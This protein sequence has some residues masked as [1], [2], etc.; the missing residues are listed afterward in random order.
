[1]GEALQ[2]IMP[3]LTGLGVVVALMLNLMNIRQKGRESNP[4]T[5]E[6]RHDIKHIR[7]RVDE[8]KVAMEKQ[9]EKMDRM[10][11]Q[12]VLNEASAKQAHKRLDELVRNK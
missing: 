3:A 10:N 8:Q 12:L 5:I 7:E 9:D 2:V 11:D 1:M 6:M 4:A